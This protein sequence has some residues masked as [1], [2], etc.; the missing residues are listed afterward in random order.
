M[1]KK[2]TSINSQ[3]I[4]AIIITDI[5]NSVITLKEAC[6]ILNVSESTLRTRVLKSEFENWEYR[7]SGGTILFCKLAIQIRADTF[8]QRNKRIDNS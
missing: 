4:N 5:I 8:R 7:K 6:K 3:E 1:R 2:E